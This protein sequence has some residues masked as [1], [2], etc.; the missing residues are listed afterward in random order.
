MSLAADALQP[1]I[2]RGLL[3][4]SGRIPHSSL[5]DLITNSRSGFDLD[6]SD[7]ERQIK[8]DFRDADYLAAAVGG[9]VCRLATAAFVTLGKI[10]E[11]IAERDKIAWSLIKLYYASFYAGHALLRLL[12]HS[13]SYLDSSHVTRLRQI[14][15]AIGNIPAFSINVGVYYGV[16]TVAQ[17][18]IDLVAQGGTTGGAHEVFWK[19][20]SAYVRSITEQVLIGYLT[21]LDAKAVFRQLAA[22]EQILVGSHSGG[23]LSSVRNNIQYRHTNGVWPPLRL[24]KSE[25]DRLPRLAAQ[26]S[27]DPMDIDIAFV[28]PGNLDAF[29]IA[30]AFA[31]SLC[32]AT[33]S[34]IAERSS[35]GRKSFACDPLAIIES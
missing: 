25:R 9:D 7:A 19:I 10:S 27:R 8:V 26:W 31:V 35:A 30:C 15:T 18:G 28:R 20:Y 1:F 13:C 2:L 4:L 3:T 34:R 12:G 21:P 32:R 24:R 33:L 17:T 6:F 22:F 29:I 23:W 16:L 5:A 11:E 14:A